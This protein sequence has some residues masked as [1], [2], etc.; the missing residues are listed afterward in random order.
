MSQAA[1]VAHA[2]P[3]VRLGLARNGRTGPQHCQALMTDPDPDVRTAAR[4]RM[5]SVLAGAGVR[6]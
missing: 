1:A 4:L 6:P 3:M 2:D 5:L